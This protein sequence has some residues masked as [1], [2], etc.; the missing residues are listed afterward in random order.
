MLDDIYQI[1]HPWLFRC[2][3]FWHENY[4]DSTLALNC[5]ISQ[6]IVSRSLSRKTTETFRALHYWSFVLG[7]HL[8][9]LRPKQNGRHF[10]D[11]I[12]KCIF[13]NENTWISIKISLKFVPRVPINNIPAL[14]QI[15]AWGRSG[16]KPLSGPMIVRLPTHI[17]V[18][19]N[20]EIP[21]PMLEYW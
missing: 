1:P 12:F 17:C 11:A 10:P 8:N 21:E 13:F 7:N 9:S 2:G 6:A 14:V 16:D 19:L 15:M 20:P 5:L 18:N 3:R 4:S